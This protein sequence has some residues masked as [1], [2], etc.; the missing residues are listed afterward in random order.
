MFKQQ[1]KKSFSK[2]YPFKIKL[3]SQAR[4]SRTQTLSP[5]IKSKTDQPCIWYIEISFFNSQVQSN[6]GNTTTTTSSDEKKE[7]TTTS[8]S[9]TSSSNTSNQNQNLGG[10]GGFGNLGGFGNFGGFGGGN[11]GGQNLG[12]VMQDP[13]FQTMMQNV[14]E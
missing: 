6:L 4:S 2:V 7:T 1:T 11:L 3:I 12:Q 14:N 5:H 10:F 13:N 8:S 9:N